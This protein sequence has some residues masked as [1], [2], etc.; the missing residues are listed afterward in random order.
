MKGF[1]EPQKRF[2]RTF[3]IEPTFFR[4]PFQILPIYRATGFWVI[5]SLVRLFLESISVA[6]PAEPH[7]EKIF[8]LLFFVRSLLKS[9]GA[10]KNFQSL[11][12]SEAVR[13]C[14]IF[15]EIRSGGLRGAK[16]VSIVFR[17]VF[18]IFRVF[19]TVLRVELKP[20]PSFPCFFF[21]KRPAKPPKKQGFFI[22]TEPP[23]SLEKK[24]KMLKKKQG[25]PHRAKNR[26]R[27]W[28]DE[29]VTGRNEVTTTFFYVWALWCACSFSGCEWAYCHGTLLC[30]FSIPKCGGVLGGND[31][32]RAEKQNVVLTWFW[33]VTRSSGHLGRRKKNKEF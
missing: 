4:L 21:G 3:R 30:K 32:N 25:I 6:T 23:K 12:K 5:F 10:V 8:Y 11:L 14:C 26:H 18:R 1:S 7:G 29:E 2:D 22:P 15:Q 27:V 20:C 13:K 19:Q 17:I 33:P 24:G 28:L 16:N 31:Q 9:L